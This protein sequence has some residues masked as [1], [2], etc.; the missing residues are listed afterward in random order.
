[1]SFYYYSKSDMTECP[2][3]MGYIGPQLTLLNLSYNNLCRIPAEIGCLRG[4]EELLLN[5]NSISSI[6]VSAQVLTILIRKISPKIQ[7]NAT[8]KYNV[9]AFI[10]IFRHFTNQNNAFT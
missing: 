10:N 2:H 5:N 9:S 3:R 4:L 1:M 8:Q 6:P 7:V